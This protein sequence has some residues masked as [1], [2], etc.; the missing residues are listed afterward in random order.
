MSNTRLYRV[1]SGIK[2]R[3]YNKNCKEY[4]HYG[5]RGITVCSEWKHDFMAFYKW[6]MASG[7]DEKAPRGK[8]TIERKEND[9]PYSPENCRWA[10]IQEQEQNKRNTVRVTHDGEEV[11]AKELSEKTGEKYCTIIKRQ[12]RRK[13]GMKSRTEY[14]A[15]AERKK[16]AVEDALKRDPNLSI[17]SI[18][19]ETGLSK[20]AV[21]R[22]C[23]GL[24]QIEE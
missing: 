8:C 17:R 21:H 18:A 23:A 19:K 5:G 11:M 14:L 13:T 3:C 7:Y 15:E 9:G 12:N 4:K 16:M 1:W 2:N 6:A 10:T 22:I 24:L 20:S